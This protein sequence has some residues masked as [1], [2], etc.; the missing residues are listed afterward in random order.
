MFLFSQDV[1]RYAMGNV[2]ALVLT[3]CSVLC[4]SYCYF[5]ML[6]KT[7]VNLYIYVASLVMCEFNHALVESFSKASRLCAEA[8]HVSF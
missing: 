4:Q 2:A 8:A 1:Y 3:F 7:E 5:S 6:A